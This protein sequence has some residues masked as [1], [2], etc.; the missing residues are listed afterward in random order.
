MTMTRKMRLVPLLAA[1]L[2]CVFVTACGCRKKAVVYT[3]RTE[4]PKYTQQLKG[5]ASE[6]KQI[7]KARAKV[8]EEMEAFRQKAAANLGGNPSAEQIDYELNS[9]PAKYPGWRELVQRDTACAEDM[10]RKL[11]EARTKV[12]ARMLQEAADREAVKDGRAKSAKK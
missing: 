9:Y 11:A 8:R 3:D 10:K 6:Q 1:A 12:R 2:L 4:D 5:I 7:A